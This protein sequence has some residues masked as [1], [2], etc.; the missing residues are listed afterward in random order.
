MTR[1]TIS[2][3]RLDN[4][5]DLIGQS[6]LRNF[7]AAGSQREI[8]PGDSF[9]RST[10]RFLNWFSSCTSSIGSIKISNE[11]NIQSIPQSMI[12]K[13]KIKKKKKII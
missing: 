12:S 11:F 1:R 10:V 2:I 8:L 4:D 5:D 13:L 7:V 9:L 6:R 3:N